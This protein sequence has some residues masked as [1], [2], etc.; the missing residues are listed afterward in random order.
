MDDDRDEK[1]R[2]E[3]GK[4]IDDCFS[5]LHE[6]FKI[7]VETYQNNESIMNN[8]EN[9]EKIEWFVD[10]TYNLGLISKKGY[11]WKSM[12]KFGTLMHD[13]SHNPTVSERLC[14][15]KLFQVTDSL[16][17]IDLNTKQAV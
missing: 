17:S 2:E 4:E 3:R 1:T 16:N 12:N 14:L 10:Y 8:A 9:K 5:K 15:G 13:F 7:I 6:Y 11:F